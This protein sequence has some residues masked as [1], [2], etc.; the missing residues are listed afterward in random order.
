M[1]N[2]TLKQEVEWNHKFKQL[3]YQ[4]FIFVGSD[5]FVIVLL[6]LVMVSWIATIMYHEKC[7]SSE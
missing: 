1:E 2:L 3:Q 4:V 7:E 6:F 5:F